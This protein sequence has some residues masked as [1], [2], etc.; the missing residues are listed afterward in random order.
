MDPLSVAGLTLGAVSLTSKI[1]S[2]CVS[3]LAGRPWHAG[4]VPLL[5]H[6]PADGAAQASRLGDISNLPEDDATTSAGLRLS[7]HLIYD[8]LH[9]IEALLINLDRLSTRC[10]LKLVVDGPLSYSPAQ[11]ETKPYQSVPVAGPGRAIKSKALKF[12]AKSRRY[13]ACL[14]WA[15]FDRDNFEALLADLTVLNDSMMYLLETGQ[16][17]AA[18][19]L[20]KT[21]FMQIFFQC[22][23]NQQAR[24]GSDDSRGNSVDVPGNSA[25]LARARH[26]QRLLQLARFK[27]LSVAVEEGHDD[28]LATSLP[29][30]AVSHLELIADELASIEAHNNTPGGLPPPGARS[31]CN[32]R[33]I[34]FSVEWK[35]YMAQG[36][37]SLPPTYIEDR[38]R[39][40]ATLLHNKQ[41]PTEFR[42]PDCMGSVHQ[43]DLERFGYVFRWPVINNTP[44]HR[45]SDLPVSLYRLLRTIECPPPLRT[46][47]ATMRAVPTS[48][49]YVHATNWLHKGLQSENIVF[50]SSQTP[51][52]QPLLV[53]PFVSG[54][55]YSRPAEAGERTERPTAN[56]LHHELYRH[57]YA[58]FDLPR[59]TGVNPS[60]AGART[61]SFTKT[62]FRKIYDF[63]ALSVVFVE[64][65]LWKPTHT[66]VGVKKG[67][68]VTARVA[69]GAWTA[70][71]EKRAYAG[72]LRAMVG[73]TVADVVIACVTGSLVGIA[74]KT[75]EQEKRA[76][77]ADVLMHIAF[78]EKVVK[79]LD[80]VIV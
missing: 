73:D 72:K 62:G 4:K 67:N 45:D 20:Q 71:A 11:P 41:K 54:F 5:A 10:K 80:E 64:I 47:L 37:D 31:L 59:E 23:D 49:S 43:P 79:K 60:A 25:S 55:E 28:V 78:E 17:S 63:Y 21:S 65:A 74:G 68:V 6:P 42:V 39:K 40:L 7:R 34:S 30:S 22:D 29:K 46:R 61:D 44:E 52:C 14:R 8:V 66:L 38:V 69:R 16:R 15:A 48:I 70:L 32:Y 76:T 13:S 18:Y 53:E 35:D 56:S 24:P 36:L 57:P 1:F 75:A 12:I 26:E 2:G 3:A 50:R 58:Q 51:T 33:D 9:Q 77:D 27:A 19:Q